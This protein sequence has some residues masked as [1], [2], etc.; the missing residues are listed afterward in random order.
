MKP[1]AGLAA[2]LICAAVLCPVP[3]SRP[4]SGFGLVTRAAGYVLLIVIA[5]EVSTRLAR[6]ESDLR[7]RIVG[8]AVWCAPFAILAVDQSA[9]A[10]VPLVALVISATPLFGLTREPPGPS[11]DA[12]LLRQFPS[13]LIAALCLQFAAGAA[14]IDRPLAA[15]AMLSICAG[16]LAWRVTA[17]DPRPRF[18]PRVQ[19]WRAAMMMA[20]AFVLAIFGMLPYQ[21]GHPA[22]GAGAGSGAGDADRQFGRGAAEFVNAET[23][24]GVI[25]R[26]E[27]PR[28]ILLAPP[29]PAL[30]RNPFRENKNSLE[31]PFFGAY[32]F[33]RRPDQRPPADSVEMRGT[34]AAL[35]FRSHNDR[36]LVV[37]AHQSLGTPFRLSCCRAV[38][39]S[40]TNRT[41]SSG[42]VSIE[43]ML[44]DT[45]D[46][47]KPFQSLGVLPVRSVFLMS[48]K[49]VGASEVL[50]FP[51]P[52]APAIQ[53]FDEFTVRFHRPFLLSRES[54]NVAV[55]GFTLKPR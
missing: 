18:H 41:R 15:G 24:R 29:L 1:I 13:S 6:A 48:D 25:L 32:W 49:G 55:D 47:G 21:A 11:A 4:F 8:A 43:L 51:I 35:T 27:A 54:A 30:N 45:F 10:A 53:Q 37:E 33:F 17:I 16:L 28:E 14:V 46:A 5:T 3:P 2:A 52:R 9:L 23:Y 44:V 22:A 36:P 42:T 38:E 39:V 40:I 7:S 12:R 19:W 20:I 31:I 26:P 50:E 34:P